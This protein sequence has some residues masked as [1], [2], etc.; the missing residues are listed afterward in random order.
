MARLKLG[1]LISG[2][3]TNL[4]ALLDA[5]ADPSFPA[6]VAV[7]IS[8][9]PGAQGLQRAAAAG[10]AA[11]TIDHKA[12]ADRAAFEAALTR[13][14]TGAGVELVCLAGFMRLLTPTF[15]ARW[16]GK[17]VNIHP[18][19]LPA[20]PGLDTHRRAIDAGARFA[21]AT[22]HFLSVEMDAGPI[23]A[24]AATPIRP[25][26]DAD[27]LAARVLVAEH[28]IYRRAVRW[29]AEGRATIVDGRVEIDGVA[30]DAAYYLPA[31]SPTV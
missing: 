8:N 28:E 2:R 10:V 11:V 13:R 18:S 15:V 30:C 5:A 21:G 12:F 25:G 22:A 3:G 9:R 26:D 23:I 29:I 14:L 20:F 24:Q 7:V 31:E 6:E 1:V 17:A 27:S 16:A 19:L 4:Q